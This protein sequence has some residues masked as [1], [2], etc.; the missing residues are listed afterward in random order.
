VSAEQKL[1][2]ARAI[3]S[4]DAPYIASILYGLVPH[5]EKGFGTMATTDHMVLLYDPDWL[6][7]LTD[8]VVAG[9]LMHECCHVFY[10]HLKRFEPIMGGEER[11]LANIAM[12][13][14]IN[15]SLIDAN[16]KLTPGALLPKYYGLPNG[17]TA[18]QYFVEL[19]KQKITMP[20]TG[21]PGSMG[22]GSGEEKQ[23]ENKE[24]NG[25]NEANSPKICSGCCGGVAGNK[26]KSEELESQLN[27][28]FGRSDSE[29]H[30]MVR[31]TG[32]S[33]RHFHERQQGRG[34]LPAGLLE[35]AKLLEEPPRID[36]R[37]HLNQVVRKATGKI[38][39][40]GKDF[41]LRRPSKRSYTRGILRP[42]LV[43]QTPEIAIIRDTSGSMGTE[44]INAATIESIAIVKASGV[45]SIWF[46][47]AD[48]KVAFQKRVR[49]SELRTLPVHGRGGTDFRPAI[50]ALVKLKPKPDIAIYITDGDGYA[51][52]KPPNGIEFIWCVVAS[53]YKR[54]PA[55]WGHLI[56]VSDENIT[57]SDP[58]S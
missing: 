28:E 39:S 7:T 1:A 15:P 19:R 32:E 31:A 44:Q 6:Q 20:N 18:E 58:L 46:L 53:Y 49:L 24:G 51:P 52:E 4:R 50:E 26:G 12:D 30:M 9:I 29:Q 55:N 17:L 14:A 10:E 37:T 23:D 35:A 48:A 34:N 5:P 25:S 54:K 57:L 42:G 56:V 3:V 45:D 36:W 27:R 11:V 47:D 41:S 2:V 22:S 40:G 33:I 16:W 43:Q 13:I 21:L 8:E 38:R